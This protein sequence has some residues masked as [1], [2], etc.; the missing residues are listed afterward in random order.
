MGRLETPTGTKGYAGLLSQLEPP[1]GTKNPTFVPASGPNQDH[2]CEGPLVPVGATNRTVPVG[3][4]NRD[5]TAPTLYH[6]L[7]PP[8]EPI[9][10][11]L[12]LFLAWVGGSFCPFPPRFVKNLRFP[13]H[14]TVIKVRS[15]FLSSFISYLAQFL[16]F[17]N[18]E[19]G[20][21]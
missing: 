11:V 8:P 12:L 4:S 2:W 5:K 15:L 13:V 3:G 18:R 10:S 20:D 16:L 21:L 14:S 7:P 19:M 1:T 9:S 17:R 6:L